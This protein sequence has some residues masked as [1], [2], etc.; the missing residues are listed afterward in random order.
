MTKAQYIKRMRK[1]EQAF[2]KVWSKMVDDTNAFIESNPDTTRIDS[3]YNPGE[4]GNSIENIADYII[5]SGAWIYDRLNG[6]SGV[7]SHANY[8]GSMTKKVRQALGYTY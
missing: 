4:S 6:K 1:N 2:S 8:R 3:I 5:K 7:P